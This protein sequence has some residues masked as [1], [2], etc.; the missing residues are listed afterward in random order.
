VVTTA[1]DIYSPYGT[2]CTGCNELL[3]APRWSA[4]VSKHEVRHFWSCDNCGHEVEMTVNAASKVGQGVERRSSR[5]QSRSA[6][7]VRNPISQHR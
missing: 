7:G 4:Y 5:Q 6:E 2:A 3:V 1:S